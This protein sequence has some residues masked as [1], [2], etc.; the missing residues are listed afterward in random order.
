MLA[1][2]ESWS[3]LKYTPSHTLFV[4]VLANFRMFAELPFSQRRSVYISRIL[5]PS[6]LFLRVVDATS[7]PSNKVLTVGLLGSFEIVPDRAGR[8]PYC[9]LGVRDDVE[10]VG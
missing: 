7:F 10:L 3:L 1:K 2:K 4:T 9:V 6:C 8:V 5:V